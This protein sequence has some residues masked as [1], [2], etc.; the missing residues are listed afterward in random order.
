MGLDSHRYCVQ[1]SHR[2]VVVFTNSLPAQMENER[3][4]YRRR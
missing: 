1:A 4:A 3:L 2:G